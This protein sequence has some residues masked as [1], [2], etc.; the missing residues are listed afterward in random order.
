MCSVSRIRISPVP[1]KKHKYYPDFDIGGV[2]Y[3]F[4]G[5]W[6]PADRRKML[7]VR[8]AHPEARIIMVFM[9]PNNKITSHSKTTYRE[10][11]ITNGFECMTYP[12]WQVHMLERKAKGEL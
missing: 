11:A 12:K 2:H 1:A 3:E 4:K 7:Q 5:R 9:R 8:D 6:L 10:W